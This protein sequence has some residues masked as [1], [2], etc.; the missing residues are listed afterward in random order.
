MKEYEDLKFYG[1]KNRLRY[2][3]NTDP[4]AIRE[5]ETGV[6]MDQAIKDK[7]QLA[8]DEYSLLRDSTEMS[9]IQHLTQEF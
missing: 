7:R 9:Q 4:F 1:M 3:E 5:A 8:R 2:I 6:V